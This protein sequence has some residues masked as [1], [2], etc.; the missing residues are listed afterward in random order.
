M[1]IDDVQAIVPI[2]ESSAQYSTARER[3]SSEAHPVASL[4]YPSPTFR[5]FTVNHDT[6]GALEIFDLV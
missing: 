3:T 5:D 4:S 1:N 2:P 6:G